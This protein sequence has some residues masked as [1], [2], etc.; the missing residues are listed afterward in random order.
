[1][2]KFIEL[3]IKELLERIQYLSNVMVFIKPINIAHLVTYYHKKIFFGDK[4][5]T[6]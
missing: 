1:M 6:V 4:I 2:N 5:I 3:I